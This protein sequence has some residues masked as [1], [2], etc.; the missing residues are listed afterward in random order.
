MQLSGRWK[1]WL[2]LSDKRSCCLTWWVHPLWGQFLS[3]LVEFQSGLKWMA[4]FQLVLSLLFKLWYLIGELW[5]HCHEQILQWLVWVWIWEVKII[6]DCNR[7]NIFP[8]NKDIIHWFKECY[9]S[10]FFL[11][12]SGDNL[13]LV[14]G[15][16][17][18]LI[19]HLHIFYNPLVERLV[20]LQ[21]EVKRD[22]WILLRSR[23]KFVNAVQFQVATWY[24]PSKCHV[25]LK[26][27]KRYS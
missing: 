6:V 21:L 1:S 13:E 15:N 16:K 4:L 2:L 26:L 25:P 17:A 10:L 11:L 22:N 7:L 14:S 12:I 5:Q 19:V 24:S 18:L 9:T 20:N 8:C 27:Q 23:S 3:L